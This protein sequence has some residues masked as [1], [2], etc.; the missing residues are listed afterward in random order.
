MGL[1]SPPDV[2]KLRAQGSVEGLV[3]AARNRDPEV[4][5]QASE[6][7][8]EMIDFCLNELST[9]NIRR[10]GVVREALVLAG[11]PAVDAMI[12]VHTDR[13]S[14]HRRQDVTFVLGEAGDPRAVPVLID[15][16]RHTDPL[17][18][19]LAAEA[20]GKIG[21]ESALRPLHLAAT[22]D[23]NRYVQKAAEKAYEKVKRAAQKGDA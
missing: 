16:L 14:V 13:Q 22:N 7:L 23:E 5:R 1:F 11:P 2:E 6:A 4:A 9:K 3:K 19:K 10:L 15:A 21:D 8:V 20:L 12:F 17:L 18:R